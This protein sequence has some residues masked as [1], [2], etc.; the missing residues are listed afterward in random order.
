MLGGWQGDPLPNLKRILAQYMP[1]ALAIFPRCPRCHAPG[2]EDS[3]HHLARCHSCKCIWWFMLSLSC[4]MSFSIM[5]LCPL[6]WLGLS[7]LDRPMGTPGPGLPTQDCG[8][9]DSQPPS[10]DPKLLKG[11]NSGGMVNHSPPASKTKTKQK[12]PC[13]VVF[14]NSLS[15]NTPTVAN[16]KQPVWSHWAWRFWKEIPGSTQSCSLSIT[17]IP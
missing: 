16:F 13:L 5:E 14:A 1:W 17:Q 4:Q 15:V 10:L 8:C 6:P 7:W 3:C 2:L 11:W 12:P 9:S